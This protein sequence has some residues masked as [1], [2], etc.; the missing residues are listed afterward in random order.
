MT[1][2]LA[3]PATFPSLEWF[4]AAQKTVNQDEG[5]ARL[6]PC[7]A[8]VGICIS[9]FDEC[10][11]L[12]L[13]D[14]R[15]EEVRPANT[16]AVEKADF[17]LEAPQQRWKDMLLNIKANEKADIAHTLA[18]MDLEDPAGLARSRHAYKR[19]LF[20]RCSQSLQ[21]FF[22]ASSRIETTFKS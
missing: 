8:V 4:R 15:V 12:T 7:D 6:G 11:L 3:R 13:R 9:D 20:Y 22:D 14:Q 18:T 21:Y 5:F 16:E 10:Y 2:S 1:E 19:R 17:W